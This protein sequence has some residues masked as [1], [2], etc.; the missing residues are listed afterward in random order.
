MRT[1]T[2]RVLAQ[3]RV[4][5]TPLHL[6]NIYTHFQWNND[7][8]LNH[9]DSEIPYAEEAFGDFK[10][11][12]EEMVYHPSPD[13]RDF[14]IYA[15]DG[16][17]IGVAYLTQISP[18]NQH[19]TVGVTIGDRR[20]WGKGYGREALDAVLG[21]CFNE[22]GMHRVS[23]ETFEYNV[24]WRRLVEGMGF[25]E[26]GVERDYLYRDGRYWDKVI[27]AILDTEYRARRAEAA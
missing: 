9:L 14:E 6:D 21:Y 8:E 18:H 1:S 19:C 15:E 10:R 16:T 5:L 12:F 13:G 24:A 17:L 25:R 26:E 4:R 7:P 11:R 22:L 27:Y 2:A 20:Y 23:A 3:G